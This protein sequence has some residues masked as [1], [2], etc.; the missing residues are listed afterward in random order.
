MF[1]C[2]SLL[3]FQLLIDVFFLQYFCLFL[4]YDLIRLRIW[5]DFSRPTSC[6]GR[7]AVLPLVIIMLVSLNE[8]VA[9]LTADQS[10]LQGV[11]ELFFQGD[12]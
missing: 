9:E 6:S 7:D 1:V 8:S 10:N 5:D 2:T 12:W 11:C 3:I 4:F